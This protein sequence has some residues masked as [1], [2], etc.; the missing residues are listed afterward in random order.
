MHWWQWCK[1]RKW[2]KTKCCKWRKW[3]QRRFIVE[4]RHWRHSILSQFELTPVLL[5]Q[6][7][8]FCYLHYCRPSTIVAICTV[9]FAANCTIVTNGPLRLTDQNLRRSW[10][11]AVMFPLQA[12]M[13]PL[14]FI[15]DSDRNITSK[16]RHCCQWWHWPMARISYHFDSYPDTITDSMCVYCLQRST[17]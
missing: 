4:Y 1:W 8:H 5:W 6:W 16:W 3:C 13:V 12:P 7:H 14:D 17:R 10:I 11:T 9:V 15:C 2:R